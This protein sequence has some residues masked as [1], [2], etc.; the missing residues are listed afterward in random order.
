MKKLITLLLSLTVLV[1]VEAQIKNIGPKVNSI[2]HEIRPLTS[3][4]GTTLYFTVQGNP[5][6]KAK[7]GQDIWMS[8]RDSLGEWGKAQRL[9]NYINSEKYNGVFSISADGNTL[10][11]RGRRSASGSTTRGFSK[12]TKL[13]NGDWSIPQPIKIHDYDRLSR[14][15][16]TGATLSPDEK[17]LI[18]YFSNEMNSDMNDLWISRLNETTGEY[19][20]PSKLSLSEEDNDEMSPYIAPDNKTLYYASDREGGLGG[21]DIW[22]T[23]RVDDTWENWTVP[24]NMGKPINSK[25]WDAYFSVDVFDKAAYITTNTKYNL[26]G[27]MG[28]ADIA[29]VKLP[30]SLLPLPIPPAPPVYDTIYITIT[31]TVYEKQLCDPLD[32]L[33]STQLVS[34]YNKGRILF[35][36]GSSV[37][38]P[39][40]YR[41]LDIIAKMMKVNP[42]MK[43]ELS[44]HTDAVG[45]DKRNIAQS[46]ERAISTKLYLMSKGIDPSRINTV[47]MG[48]KAP[49]APNNTDGGRQ[50]NRRVDMKV[51]Q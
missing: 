5:I 41:Q 4:D 35:D 28:G 44:G 51:V 25:G 14:G 20:T 43:I 27:N 9:P 2:Y 22:M 3:A 12:I 32:A 42:N 38:R 49:V 7:D 31:D 1:G 26:P 34:E 11:I 50:L 16:Y 30:D 8:K 18:M 37:L 46:E 23:R 29:Y 21:M 39:D 13:E 10:V 36:F 24:V 45:V 15:I 33:D 47:G 6:N 17:V 48:N 19:S 40:S